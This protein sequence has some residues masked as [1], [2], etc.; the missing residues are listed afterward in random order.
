[1]SN[2]Y[3]L[4]IIIVSFN[5]KDLT[6]R[7]IRAAQRSIDAL[8]VKGKKEI[9]VVD[10]ASH[11]GSVALIRR[12]CPDIKLLINLKNK[13]FAVA[14]NRAIRIA[15]G[16][17]YLLLNSD[18]FLQANALS[19]MLQSLEEDSSIGVVG[20]K[21]LNSDGTLQ[22]S[23]GFAPTLWR[24]AA[25]MMFLDDIPILSSFMRPYHAG[26]PSFY[27]ADHDVD[28]VTG[29]CLLVRGVAISQAGLMDE[30]IFMYGEEIEWQCRL[31][32]AGWRVK[33][34]QDASVVHKKGSSGEGDVS[35]IVEEFT[36]LRHFYAR[37]YPGWQEFALRI[38]LWFGALLRI[39]V[40]GIIGRYPAR[41]RLYAKALT[42][43]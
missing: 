4:S 28:W 42:L 25:W 32:K 5:T 33:Y 43:A 18:A 26:N 7:C 41:V 6:L 11:D 30:G 34:I 37:H 27:G 16:K 29:A 12:V 39:V 40:F 36:S 3:I 24:V 10:N 15:K 9:I 14:N 8:T 31:R 38:F 13:G 2:P 1:M 22:Q 17:Y 19:R 35:G 23:S 21:L 20:P